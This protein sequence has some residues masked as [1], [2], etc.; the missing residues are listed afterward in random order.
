MIFEIAFEFELECHKVKKKD[1]ASYASWF[2]TQKYQV[3]NKLHNFVNNFQDSWPVH[4]KAEALAYM[5]LTCKQVSCMLPYV[6][7]C[8]NYKLL[9]Y[10]LYKSRN[11]KSKK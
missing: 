5:Q 2:K 6:I 3:W 9:Y 11:G 10:S 8:N 1:L 7:A 4:S